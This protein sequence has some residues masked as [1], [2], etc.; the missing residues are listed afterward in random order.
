[1]D[2]KCPPTPT[3]AVASVPIWGENLRQLALWCLL[4]QDVAAQAEFE[5]RI[6]KPRSMFKGTGLNPVAFKP[7]LGQQSST[8]TAPPRPD[9]GDHAIAALQPAA[10]HLLAERRGYGVALQALEVDESTPPFRLGTKAEQLV[11]HL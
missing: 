2:Q 3:I 4:Y 11:V 7:W 10:D 1:M 5:R 6:L 9:V 8:S